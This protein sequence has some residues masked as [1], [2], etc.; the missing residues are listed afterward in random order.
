MTDRKIRTIGQ[1]YLQCQRSRVACDLEMQKL[2]EQELLKRGVAVKE[3]L[4]EEERAEHAYRKT[5]IVITDEI[6]AQKYLKELKESKEYQVLEQ[7]KAVLKSEESRFLAA[8]EEIFSDSQIWKFCENVRGLGSVAAMTFFTVL[9]TEAIMRQNDS[10]GFNDTRKVITAGKV[11]KYLGLAPGQRL[12]SGKLGGF[13]TIMKGRTWM[14]SRNV[15]MANDP[16]YAEIYR[17]EKEFYRNRP[18]L[19]AENGYVVRCPGDGHYI[20]TQQTIK[21][22][23]DEV[24]CPICREQV[25]A[26]EV[27]SHKKKPG[28]KKWIDA[29]A[30]RWMRKILLSHVTEIIATSEGCEFSKHANYVPP[31]PLLPGEQELILERFRNERLGLLDKYI[32]QFAETGNAQTIR[33]NMQSYWS[34]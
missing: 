11:W 9:D 28:W 33:E 12:E 7:H 26:V 16:Y 15:I 2:A 13:N 1:V 22:K 10:R 30:S 18:D 14:I 23:D 34:K 25:K 3:I 19:I 29:M 27:V 24:Y 4:T 17:I 6:L 32:R 31:K 21:G 8:A 5:K 20:A